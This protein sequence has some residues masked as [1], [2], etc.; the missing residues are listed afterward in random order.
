MRRFT[1]IITSLILTAGIAGIPGCCTLDD[2]VSLFE[3]EKLLSAVFPAV[4]RIESISPDYA[5]GRRIRQQAVGSGVIISK[6]GLVVT[7]HHV[8]GKSEQLLCRFT[9]GSAVSGTLVGTDAMTDIAVIRLNLAERQSA[10][11]LTVAVW[12]NS[13]NL[14]I[15]EPV[16]AMGCPG[17]L[18]QSMTQGIIANTGFTFP[19]NAVQNLRLDGA[20]VGVLV[21]WILHDAQIFGGNSGGPLVN[22]SGEIV[23]INELSYA[24]LSGAVPS[25]LARSITEQLVKSGKVSRAWSGLQYQALLPSQ[26]DSGMTGALIAG[27]AQNSPAEKSGIEPGDILISFNNRPVTGRLPEDIPALNRLEM[28]EAIGSSV[29]LGVL[30]NSQIKIFQLELAARPSDIFDVKLSESWDMSALDLTHLLRTEAQL[31]TDSGVFVHSVKINGITNTATPKIMSGDVITAVDGHAVGD[32][33]DLNALTDSLMKGK[34]G[35]Q[36]LLVTLKRRDETL[37]SI[38]KF[39][40]PKENAPAR[41]ARAWFPASVQVLTRDLRAYLQLNTLRGVRITEVFAGRSAEKAGFKVGD[42]IIGID[43]ERLDVNREEDVTLFTDM[44]RQY[45]V[46]SSGT[47][48]VLRDGKKMSITLMFENLPATLSA[49][50]SFESELLGMTVRNLNFDEKMKAEKRKEQE[51]VAIQRIETGSA[52]AVAQLPQSGIILSVNG[53]AV[54]TVDQFKTQVELAVAEHRKT[55][56][57]F[58]RSGIYTIYYEVRL[59]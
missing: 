51:G 43:G 9:D 58:V 35:E 39:N 2:T 28:S 3:K 14:K 26:S 34:I 21:R 23:G 54:S 47:F 1:Q 12:G 37:L 7:N 44:I 22:R 50:D 25:N 46:G 57:L 45:R 49:S 8:A 38:V 13:E 24:G 36:P 17:A 59:K 10:E 42:I 31:S 48:D 53:Q 16:F 29:M 6:D 33:A 15:G 11:P 20:Q 4:M 32:I 55:L 56:V 27:I 52:A 18:A 30:R 5:S 19:G 40:P 41:A